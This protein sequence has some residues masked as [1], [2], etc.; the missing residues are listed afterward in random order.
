VI[1]GLARQLLTV[2]DQRD[3][4]RTEL[5]DLLATDPLAEIL[6][7]MPG[8]GQY[9]AWGCSR[10]T[11]TSSSGLPA[12]FPDPVSWRILPNG[13]MLDRRRL[14]CEGSVT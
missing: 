14:S 8:V 1:R 3:T 11:S 5:E 2:L 4:L 9:S 13:V 6:T 12:A 10:S 7:S